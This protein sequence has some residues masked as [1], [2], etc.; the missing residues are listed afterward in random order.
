M[1]AATVLGTNYPLSVGVQA[2]MKLV[3]LVHLTPLERVGAQLPTFKHIRVD[4]VKAARAG[5]YILMVGK[6]CN[7]GSQK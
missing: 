7:G 6:L 4:H 2:F 3:A 5:V 1:S